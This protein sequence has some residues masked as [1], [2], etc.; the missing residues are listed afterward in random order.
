MA[1]VGS[2]TEI[3]GSPEL[4]VAHGG[5]SD[6][7]KNSHPKRKTKGLILNEKVQDSSVKKHILLYFLA[8]LWYNKPVRNCIFRRFFHG[9]CR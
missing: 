8:G 6:R 7:A 5:A 9:C 2:G 4:P 1:K 3:T